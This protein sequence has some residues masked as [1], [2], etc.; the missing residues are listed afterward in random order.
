MIKEVKYDFIKK[1]KKIVEKERVDLKENW[2][3][4]YWY[5]LDNIL[6]WFI[7]VL[8][9]DKTIRFKSDYIFKEFRWNWYYKELFNFRLNLFKKK[10]KEISAFCTEKSIWTY[11]KNW[12]NIINK[13]KNWIYFVKYKK[14]EEL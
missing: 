7:W 11:L 13:N 3:T 2:T 6:V 9:K 12:F 5:F 1:Y 8:E 4:Y 10:N 14:Y